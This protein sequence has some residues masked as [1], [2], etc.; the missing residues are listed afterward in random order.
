MNSSPRLNFTSGT[1]IFHHSPHEQSIFVHNIMWKW[2]SKNQTKQHKTKPCLGEIRKFR[3]G[4]GY[5]SKDIVYCDLSLSKWIHKS[6][7]TLNV[8]RL[9]MLKYLIDIFKQRVFDIAQQ[10]NWCVDIKSFDRLR[11]YSQFKNR[12]NPKNIYFGG[13][14]CEQ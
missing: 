11:S 3:I 7:H 2:W 6:K 10:S 12:L 4:V 13:W 8:I 9:L 5:F 1:I 14:T